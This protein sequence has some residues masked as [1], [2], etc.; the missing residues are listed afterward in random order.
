MIGHASSVR[1]MRGPAAE[2]APAIPASDTPVGTSG[3]ERR[4]QAMRHKRAASRVIG[5]T[6]VAAWIIGLGALMIVAAL[7]LLVLP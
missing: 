7:G 5:A 2:A 3:L 1:P 4:I 6:E